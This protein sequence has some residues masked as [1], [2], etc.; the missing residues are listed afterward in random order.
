MTAEFIREALSFGYQTT[1]KNLFFVIKFY[2]RSFFTFLFF[3]LLIGLPFLGIAKFFSI[4]VTA[5]TFKPTNFTPLQNTFIVFAMGLYLLFFSLC[6]DLLIFRAWKIAVKFFR[7][8]TSQI[9]PLFSNFSLSLRYFF[10]TLLCN[11]LSSAATLPI[12]FLIRLSFNL[13][14][15]STQ[16][17]LLVLTLSII[18]SL[19]FLY[20][21]LRLMFYPIIILNQNARAIESL[22]KSYALTSGANGTLT[23]KLFLISFCFLFAFYLPLFILPKASLI[24]SIYATF[25][26]LLIPFLMYIF[27]LAITYLGSKF[28]KAQ[29]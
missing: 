22:K 5:S 7:Y 14:L 23:L 4:D 28:E 17:S 2:L 8:G 13:K 12:A 11:A 16:P 25:F 18:A 24:Y 29:S 6:K 21:S 19:I 26:F 1:K 3:L 9:D 15:E 27:I 20:I 10:A